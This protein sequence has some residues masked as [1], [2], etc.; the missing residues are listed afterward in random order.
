MTVMEA[1]Q[2]RRSVRQYTDTPLAPEV[3][4]QLSEAFRLAPSA[5]NAQDWQLI[6][7]TDPELKKA[8]HPSAMIAQAPAVLVA[9]GLAQNMMPCG[10]RADSVD[11]SIGLSFVMLQAQAL[12][13]GTCWIGSHTEAQVRAALGLA[14][15]VSIPAIMPVGYPAESPD[16]KP[17]K[18]V[19]DV[20]ICK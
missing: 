12:G 13:L 2:A 1:I 14:D 3:L 10:H 19:G 8:L 9:C 4:A 17:R 11:L 6:I 7:V 5:R 20:V 16:A 18:D 15:S